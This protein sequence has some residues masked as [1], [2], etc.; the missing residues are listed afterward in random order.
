MMPSYYSKKHYSVPTIYRF[1]SKNQQFV[2][3]RENI[4]WQNDK[5]KR[6]FR[7]VYKLEEIRNL[8]YIL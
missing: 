5:D 4:F 2:A 1:L 6:T 7:K 8:L 3:L